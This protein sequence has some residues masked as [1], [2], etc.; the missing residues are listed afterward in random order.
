MTGTDLVLPVLGGVRVL[1]IEAAEDSSAV[2]TAV[3]RL[4]GFDARSARTGADG[5]AA[6]ATRRPRVVLIDLDLPGEDA[7]AVI[8]RLRATADPPAVV[9][10]TGH[11]ARSWR[12]AA[13]DAGAAAYLLKPAQPTELVTLVR[14]LC[15]GD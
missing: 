13:A 7:C 8:R 3:L 6:A 12:R 10:V 1:V 15:V 14:K 11:T 5:L 4:H 9:V 2:L